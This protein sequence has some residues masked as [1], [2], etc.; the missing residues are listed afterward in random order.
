M[1]GHPSSEAEGDYY[2]RDLFLEITS[3][4]GLFGLIGGAKTD[5]RSTYKYQ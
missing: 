2:M 3:N 5:T 1:G 4:V